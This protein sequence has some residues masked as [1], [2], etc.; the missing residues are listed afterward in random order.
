VIYGTLTY[1]GTSAADTFIVNMRE[2]RI[3]VLQMLQPSDINDSSFRSKWIILEWENKINIETLSGD[4]PSFLNML[5]DSLKMK[6][7]N[8]EP[9]LEGQ[10]QVNYLVANLAACTVSGQDVLMNVCVRKDESERIVGHCRIRSQLQGIVFSLG[11]KVS[12]CQ[13]AD[14]FA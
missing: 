4:I 14:A 7:V 9:R 2:I 12:L 5:A 10:D 1:D 8:V 6:F 11:E 3:D 13:Q